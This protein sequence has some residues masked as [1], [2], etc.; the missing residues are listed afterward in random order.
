MVK[1]NGPDELDAVLAFNARRDIPAK[2]EALWAPYT[3]EPEAYAR[4]GYWLFFENGTLLPEGRECW[5]FLAGRRVYDF[6]SSRPK[7]P[8]VLTTKEPG[9]LALAAVF[10]WFHDVTRDD[11]DEL[12]RE[13]DFEWTSE[14]VS[15]R[16]Q[17]VTLEQIR[18]FRAKHLKALA[19]ESLTDPFQDL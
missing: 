3:E 8:F 13:R 12:L 9:A 4:W 7:R 18:E 16:G 14:S 19:V 17:T 1:L 6:L 15:W 2:V 11:F 5:G 10:H